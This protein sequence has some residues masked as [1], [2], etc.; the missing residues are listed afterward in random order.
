MGTKEN[1]E[2]D[3]TYETREA[4]TTIVEPDKITEEAPTGTPGGPEM[5]EY[6]DHAV[7]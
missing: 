3:G 2:W 1:G 7:A 5:E 4:K 6:N